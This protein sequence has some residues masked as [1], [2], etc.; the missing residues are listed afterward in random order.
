MNNCSRYI[1]GEAYID[2]LYRRSSEEWLINTGIKDYCLTPIDDRWGILHVNMNETG[3]VSYGEYGYTSFPLV[4]GVQDYGAMRE[5]GI[6]RARE[7]PYL[8]LRGNGTLIGVVDTG[9]MY[10]H[11][12]FVREDKTTTIEAIWDQTQERKDD[13]DGA[14]TNG[15]KDIESL[16]LYGRVYTKNMINEAL[17]SDSPLSIV[18]VTDIR[19]GHGTMIAGLAAGRENLEKGFTGAAPEA[20]LVVVKLRQAKSYLRSFYLVNDDAL[21]YSET[22]II[23]GIRFIEEYANKVGKPVSII[24]GLGT[25]LSSHMGSSVLS[26]FIDNIG[27]NI[28]RSISVCSGNYANSRLH[29][30]GRLMPDADYIPIEIR[31]GENERGFWCGLWSEPPEVFS[32][33]FVSPIGRVEQRVP[34]KVNEKITLRFTLEGTTIEVFYGVNQPVSGLNV[35]A[36]RF[37][38]PSAGIWTIRAYGDGILSGGFNMWLS[39]KEFLWSD[40]YFLQPDPYNTITDPG[41]ASVPVTVGAYNYRDGGMYI[42]SGRGRMAAY[43]I[44]PDIVAPGV[45]VL[46]PVIDGRNSYGE[47]TGSSVAA[48]IAGGGA[49]LIL[50]YGIVRGFYPYLRSYTVKNFLV[51]GAVRKQGQRYPDP[52]YGYGLLNIYNAIEA[53]RR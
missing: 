47:R 33:E 9:I 44:K 31:V 22:D 32:L 15:D 30:T 39:N 51:S 36:L 13:A 48:A 2:A 17:A 1:T 20:G 6:I 18:P 27:R 12:V 16:A 42:G 24:I 11:E 34:P 50:E 29:F 3:E 41:N 5:A 38:N 53:I 7:Q 8:N 25:N 43:G 40:T 10:T 45:N 19:D 28:G 46:S 21:C 35:V 49:A 26:D 14:M 23:L 37:I 4:Y 52:L